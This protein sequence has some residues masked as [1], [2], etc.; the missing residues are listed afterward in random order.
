MCIRL[1]II[2]WAEAVVDK[3]LQHKAGN[4]IRKEKESGYEGDSVKKV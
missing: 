1:R 3:T 2:G 4:N